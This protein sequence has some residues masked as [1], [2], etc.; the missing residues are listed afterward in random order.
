MQ[1]D[2]FQRS[3]FAAGLAARFAHLILSEC[4]ALRDAF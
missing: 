3:M 2:D 1:I 4:I